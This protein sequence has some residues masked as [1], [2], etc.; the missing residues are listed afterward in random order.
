MRL[1]PGDTVVLASDGILHARGVNDQPFGVDRLI[2]LLSEHRR[3]S[4]ECMV[5]IVVD[6]VIEYSGNSV[7][8]DDLTVLAFRFSRDD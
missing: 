5:G 7:P 4:P 3:Q 8:A 6:A 2:E 1:F